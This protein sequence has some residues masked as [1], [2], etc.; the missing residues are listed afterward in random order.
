MK[1]FSI[2]YP[3]TLLAGLNLSSESF[4]EEARTALAVKLFEMGK[5]SSGQAADLAGVGRAEFLLNS[6]RFGAPS[7]AWDNDEMV[8]EFG[9]RR[10]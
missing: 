5:L 1:R 3:E 10:P 2:E 7:V 4:E 6:H 8:A 9:E